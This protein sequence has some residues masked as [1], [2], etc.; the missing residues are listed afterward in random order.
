MQEW[1]PWLEIFGREHL[2][3]SVAALHP[4]FLHR[5]PVPGPSHNPPHAQTVEA[6]GARRR[7]VQALGAPARPRPG[8]APVPPRPAHCA[9][10]PVTPRAG[11]GSEDARKRRGRRSALAAPHS[12]VARRPPDHE[13]ASL[14]A[15]PPASSVASWAPSR[16][17]AAAWLSDRRRGSGRA[18]RRPGG[19]GPAARPHAVQVHPLRAAPAG[20]R[21]CAGAH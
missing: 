16:G 5:R 7:R 8:P 11:P 3:R 2:R 15:R 9:S 1:N 6:L 19:P 12:R 21:T 14:G 17:P 18:G 20:R 10:R 4:S 13:A